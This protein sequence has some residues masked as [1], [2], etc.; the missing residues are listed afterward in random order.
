[1]RTQV[2][3]AFVS[4]RKVQS[5]GAPAAAASLT[6]PRTLSLSDGITI[7]ETS[8]AASAS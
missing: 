6:I 3:P 2:S 8:L 7:C 1:M 4:T 5:T